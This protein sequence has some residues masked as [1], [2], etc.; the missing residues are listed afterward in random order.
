MENKLKLILLFLFLVSCNS[1]EI[2]VQNQRNNSSDDPINDTEVEEE[3]GFEA[4]LDTSFATNGIGIHGSAGKA[5]NIAYSSVVDSDGN[6]YAVGFT[7]PTGGSVVRTLAVWKFDSN[8]AIDTSFGNSGIYEYVGDSSTEDSEGYDI[9]FDADGKLV[10]VGYTESGGKARALAMRLSRSGV[11][12]TSFGSSGYYIFSH[13]NAGAS[14]GERARCIQIDS[15]GSIYLA[16]QGYFS[17]DKSLKIWKLDSSG[18]LDTGFGTSGVWEHHGLG[19]GGGAD[20]IFACKL[21]GSRLIIGGQTWGGSSHK[22][23]IGKVDLNGNTDTSFGDASGFIVEDDIAGGLNRPDYLDHLEIRADG[24]ILVSGRSHNGTDYDAYIYTIDFNGN[25]SSEK[26]MIFNDLKGNP[27]NDI[28]LTS[29]YDS[30]SETLLVGGYTMGDNSVQ[31]GY[32]GKINTDDETL[33][34]ITEYED[35]GSNTIRHFS[36]QD[37]KVFVIGT[38]TNATTQDIIISRFK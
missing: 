22:V 25:R 7:T 36:S 8:G 11:L 26:T 33:E 19:G 38:E 3:A 29:Y 17:N 18:S 23:F 9:A 4:K 20:K 24:Q 2:T 28:I 21:H 1:S 34:I 32:V 37:Q 14:E 27:G 30:E 12:D 6:T 10:V 13:I 35:V 15:S 16:G 31:I 5:K